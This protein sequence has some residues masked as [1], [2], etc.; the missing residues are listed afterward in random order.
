MAGRPRKNE[1]N[2]NRNGTGTVYTS[3]QKVDRGKYRLNKM[4][5]ICSE[6]TDR[7]I[8]EN[9]VGTKKCSKCLECK[10]KDCDRFYI[11][12]PHTALSSTKGGKKRKYLGRYNKKEEAQNSIIQSQTGGFI[13]TN[14]VTLYEVLEQKN[15]K[16]LEANV[17][18]TSTDD[19]NRAIRDKMRKYGLADKRIQKISTDEIQN[20]LNDLKD[21]YSQSEIDKQTDEIKSGYKFAIINHLTSVNP[22]ENLIKVISSLSVKNARPFELD[23]QNI[24][25]EYI[26]THDNLTDIRSDMDSIT[27]KNV[28]KLAFATGQRIGEL[29]ALQ[30]GYD[31]KHYTS[32]INFEKKYF[33][34]SKTISTDHNKPILKNGTKNS[35]KRIR[36]GL[37]PYIDISFN[38]ACDNVI[39]NILKEQIEHTKNNPNNKQHFLFCNDDGSFLTH[40]QITDT[41]KRICRQ[42]H[43]QDDNPTGCFIHQARHSF[44]TRCL[45]AGMNI[46]TIADIIGDNIEQVLDTYAHILKR[47]KD[48]EL[49]KL[50]IYY[51]NNNIIF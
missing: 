47:F 2:K 38:V 11:Y 21:S 36:K 50:H 13:E 29:L 22:C 32:D 49:D 31:K 23:E 19:R 43:I 37:P 25:L 4:C 51:K 48:D 40:H 17:I 28:V 3:V 24:L 45:E 35:K 8:C 46:E 16:N 15:T 9:R 14:T 27:F 10:G 44:V 42:L 39:E 1:K 7:S 12:T 41:L 18:S 34:I 20:Y 5:K 6:C 33:R 30:I 26:N